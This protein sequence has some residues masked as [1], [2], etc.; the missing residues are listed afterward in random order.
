MDANARVGRI[1]TIG[2][3][4]VG[5]A[6][7]GAAPWLGWWT[8][9]LFCASALNFG[10][11]DWLMAR[12]HRP[13]WV[14]ARAILVTLA[15]LATGAVLSGGPHGA[16]LLFLGVGEQLFEGVGHGDAERCAHDVDVPLPPIAVG[17]TDGQLARACSTA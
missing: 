1:R 8:L 17:T 13:E 4:A 5:L 14:S 11:V 7:L 16:A 15:L 2:S 3:A 12:S 9:I 6:L 10:S